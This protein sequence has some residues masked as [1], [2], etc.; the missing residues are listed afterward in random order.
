MSV[1]LITGYHIREDSNAHN[2][3]CEHHS[4]RIAEVCITLLRLSLFKYRVPL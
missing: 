2:R 1:T 3:R 4:A